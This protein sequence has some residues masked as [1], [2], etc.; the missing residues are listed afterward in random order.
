MITIEE[1]GRST[2]QQIMH[3]YM[4]RYFVVRLG[5]GKM[6]AIVGVNNQ[7]MPNA[8]VVGIATQYRVPMYKV[9][10]NMQMGRPC[11]LNDT[12]IH[13]F[14][15]MRYM[16]VDESVLSPALQLTIYRVVAM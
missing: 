4:G 2:L 3:T 10:M 15:S 14:H 7:S 1:S 13:S 16:K 11:N 8:G 9:A 6:A 12:R 5:A